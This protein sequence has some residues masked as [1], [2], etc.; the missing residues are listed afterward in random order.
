MNH[1]VTAVSDRLLPEL[2]ARLRL[3]FE[4]GP[5]AGGGAAAQV[6]AGGSAGLL[7]PQA[8]VERISLLRT[9]LMSSTPVK[10]A[11]AKLSAYQ[12]AV[13][14]PVRGGRGG[15]AAFGSPALLQQLAAGRDSAGLTPVG[16]GEGGGQGGGGSSGAAGG[17][18][19]APTARL[20]EEV[21]A[22]ALAL[23]NLQLA[24]AC[25]HQLQRTLQHDLSDYFSAAAAG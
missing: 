9:A 25:A 7:L 18:S 10:L 17:R 8:Q 19:A 15:G 21:A 23:N 16:G 3:A 1:I 22:A 13:P 14:S 24:V 12:A 11:A 4:D 6:T 5:T 20:T 2:E